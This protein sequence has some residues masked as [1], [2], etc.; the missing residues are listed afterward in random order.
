MLFRYDC[1]GPHTIGITA[2]ATTGATAS[3]SVRFNKE[4]HAA[5]STASGEVEA[6]PKPLGVPSRYSMCQRL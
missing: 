2:R 1:S 5:S 4:N 6:S 3:A